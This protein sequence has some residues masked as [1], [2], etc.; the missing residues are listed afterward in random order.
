MKRIFI[1]L[2][3][4][5]FVTACGGGG[6]SSGGSSAP[7]NESGSGNGGSGDEGNEGS[8]NEDDTTG[9][10]DGGNAGFS[11]SSVDEAAKLFA[12]T[13]GAW[14]VS[15]SVSQPLGWQEKDTFIS[16]SQ[17]IPNKNEAVATDC[18]ESGSTIN[19][20]KNKII[21][22]PLGGLNF[23][24]RV[25]EFN[26]CKGNGVFLSSENNTGVATNY[27]GMGQLNYFSSIE[28]S[29]PEN[30]N[31]GRFETFS[32]PDCSNSGWIDS[33]YNASSFSVNREDY[34][35]DISLKGSGKDYSTSQYKRSSDT[36]Q[37]TIVRNANGVI[38]VSGATCELPEIGFETS[39]TI[40]SK[41]LEGGTTPSGMFLSR[42]EYQNGSMSFKSTSGDVLARFDFPSFNEVTVTVDGVSKTFSSDQIFNLQKSCTIK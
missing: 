5:L 41:I 23:L 3:C 22:S 25:S 6:S 31:S 13:S 29:H 8:D 4:L 10:D 11:F 19:Y 14:V 34:E 42:T 9:G 30:P 2:A 35:I 21:D 1:V 36:P 24:V 32:C 38:S 18:P 15:G 28:K 20:K 37:T 12:L 40:T 33:F 27:S 17:S 16:D 39:G 7:T 26:D